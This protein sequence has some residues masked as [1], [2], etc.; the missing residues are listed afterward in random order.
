MSTRFSTVSVIMSKDTLET[1]FGLYSFLGILSVSKNK[2]TNRFITSRI[3]AVFNVLKM[4]LVLIFGAVTFRN[5]H[6][7]NLF[8]ED[9]FIRSPRYS[10]FLKFIV[11]VTQQIVQVNSFFICMLQFLRRE[12][13]T[14]FLNH[15]KELELSPTYK[16]K[17]KNIWRKFFVQISSLF[18][19]TL[20]IQYL[21]RGRITLL[22][23]CGFALFSHSYVVMSSFLSLI[24]TFEIYFIICLK[25][26]KH[27]LSA[28]MRN[29][30]LKIYLELISQYQ[31]I[32]DISREFNNVFGT[33]VTSMSCCVTILTIFQVSL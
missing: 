4:P 11:E 6:L 13:I 33:Q 16:M 3:H 21:F 9:N 7:L 10:D 32:F 28:N 29:N 27:R 12:Q 26:F 25:D 15:A 1:I 20:I 30:D 24:K 2:S 19:I 5:L 17:L 22:S 18:M 23:L 31:K 14:L 8:F